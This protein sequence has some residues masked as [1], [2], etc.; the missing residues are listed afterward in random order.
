MITITVA[1]KVIMIK[2][3]SNIGVGN[4]GGVV[5]CRN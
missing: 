4:S 2:K 3:V 5:G 1:L